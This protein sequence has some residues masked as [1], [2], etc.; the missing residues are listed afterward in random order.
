MSIPSYLRDI[1]EE[2]SAG[3]LNE[4]I[5]REKEIAQI[6]SIISQEGKSNVLV[7]GPAG[8]G[9]T[10]IIEGLAVKIVNNEI[11][12]NFPKRR[13]YELDVTSIISGTTYRGEFEQKVKEFLSFAK[14]NNDA[15]IFIDEI[16]TVI[17]L[18][19]TSGSG[20]SGDMSQ[21]LKPALARGE[22]TCIG[23]TTMEEYNMYVLPDG[24]FAR[25]F[26]NINLLPPSK[27]DLFQILKRSSIKSGLTYG[28]EL[29]DSSINSIIE[30]SDELFPNRNQ[31]DKGLDLL[32]R[33]LAFYSL[34]NKGRNAEMSDAR[35]V[36][37]A[38][39]LE[40]ELK[41]L[42][43]NQH[44]KLIDK[45]M[46]WLGVKQNVIDKVTIDKHEIFK[47]INSQ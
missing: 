45:A 8:V 36:D 1:T 44:S 43:N 21:M 39:Y 6:L 42:K 20:G 9:K 29:S 12:D 38:E 19:K 24:A 28:I 4:P 31:P 27:E 2:A 14:K 13:I 37:Y 34:Q 26:H 47:I 30:V 22:F 5:G 25:R 40:V 33:I 35:L 32:K 7:L 15:I 11:P 41:L 18:G 17:G 10:A 3:L 23:A 46:E 16:H